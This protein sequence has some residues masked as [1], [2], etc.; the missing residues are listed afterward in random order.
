V[1]SQIQSNILSYVARNTI[2]T[3]DGRAAKNWWERRYKGAPFTLRSVQ[4]IWGTPLAD[5]TQALPHIEVHF[6]NEYAVR[7]DLD[8]TVRLL[9]RD[10]LI[11]YEAFVKK[12][13]WRP[14]KV[15][16][17]M[18]PFFMLLNTRIRHYYNFNA[19]YL[20][21][22]ATDQPVQTYETRR[23]VKELL[24]REDGWFDNPINESNRDQHSLRV[25]HLRKTWKKSNPWM[26]QNRQRLGYT[27]SDRFAI[28]A[29][30][31]ADW[32]DL[33]PYT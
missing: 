7:G 3:A 23:V 29:S 8:K 17:L 13:H 22:M 14:T 33:A 20:A 10:M 2:G 9:V 32:L 1:K 11:C 27:V 4:F 25:A 19:E 28:E 5:Y 16:T 12:D 24:T 31:I 26:R 18:S 21:R 15:I 30:T 6:L